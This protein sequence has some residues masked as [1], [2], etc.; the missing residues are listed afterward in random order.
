MSDFLLKSDIGHF[1]SVG[2]RINIQHFD[3]SV[4]SRQTKPHC[5]LPQ[6]WG[7]FYLMLFLDFRRIPIHLKKWSI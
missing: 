2:F 3:P 6:F 7:Q 4:L 5:G 1:A